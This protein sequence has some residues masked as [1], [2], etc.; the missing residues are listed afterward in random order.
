MLW[1]FNYSEFQYYMEDTHPAIVS[2]DIYQG[3]QEEMAKRGG[4]IMWRCATRIEKG[5][6]PCNDL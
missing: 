6:T 3:V 4:K 1:L 5:K 2:K